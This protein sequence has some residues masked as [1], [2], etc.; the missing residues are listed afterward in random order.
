MF[1]AGCW[2]YPVRAHI[3]VDAA[4][5][6]CIPGATRILCITGNRKHFLKSTYGCWAVVCNVFGRHAGRCIIIFAYGELF[7]FSVS[8]CRDTMD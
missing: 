5:A 8:V 7:H 2:L 1:S 3:P 4:A 6:G